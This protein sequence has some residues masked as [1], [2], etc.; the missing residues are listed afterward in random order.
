MVE[1]LMMTSMIVGAAAA[2]T[3]ALTLLLIVLDVIK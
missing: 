2:L 1:V 3:I